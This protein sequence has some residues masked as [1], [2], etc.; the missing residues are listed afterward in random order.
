[1]SE[2]DPRGASELLRERSREDITTLDDFREFFS[3]EETG[4]GGF[5]KAPWSEEE[6]T[7]ETMAELGFSV[8]VIPFG[9]ELPQDARCVIT[10]GPARVVAIFAK[11]Y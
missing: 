9:E 11:A 10:G 5:I 4:S 2:I 3:G 8:R 7:L 6:D 1:M